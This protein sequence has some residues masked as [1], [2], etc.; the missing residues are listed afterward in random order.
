ME[1]DMAK[2]TI[3]NLRTEYLVN[4]EGID[5]KKPR[6]SW[7]LASESRGVVQTA[8]QILVSS[9]SE[10]LKKNRGNIWN[11]GTVKKQ[12]T[13]QIV[14][15]GKLLN[16]YKQYFWKV[17]VW[18]NKS[19]KPT[20]W[21]DAACW[22]MGIL[23]EKK[24][25]GDWIAY[26][27][28][29]I[30]D[31]PFFRKEIT[32]KKKVKRAM[33]YATSKGIYEAR[34]NGEKV[35]EDIFTPGWTDY[36]KRLYYNTYDVTG[37]LK[38]GR[39]AIGAILGEGWYKGPIGWSGRMHTYGQY[40]M[41]LANL[42]IEFADGTSTVIA[43][44]KT[45]KTSTGPIFLSTFLWGETYDSRQELGEWDK[46]GYDESDWQKVVTQGFNDEYWENSVN[47]MVRRTPPLQAYPNEPVRRTEYLDAQKVWQSPKGSWIFDLGQNFAG[48]A[49]IRVKEKAGT[50]IR[51]RYG[52]MCEADN[53][54][55]VEN[56]RSAWS[57]DTYICKGKGV[58]EWEPRFTFHG[59]RYVEITGITSKP[60]K[61][62]VTGVVTGS[63][64]NRVGD[65]SCS[66][67]MINQ[68]YSNTVWTQRANFLEIPTDCP[69]RDERLGWTGDAQAYIRT[70]SCNMDIAA[71]FKKWLVDLEDTQ[72][73]NGSVSNVAPSATLGNGGA[74]SGWG[75][76]VVICP[77]TIY[78]VYGDTTILRKHWNAMKK[79]IGY[80]KSTSKG[81]V[82]GQTHCF[83]DWLSINADT[84]KD[85]IQTAFF[86]YVTDLMVRMA[87]VL[88]KKKDEAEYTKLLKDIKKAFNKAFVKANGRIKGD[89]QTA[90]VLALHFDLLSEKLVPKAVKYL[91]NDIKKK[92]NHLSTG[93]LGTPYLLHVL[94]RYGHADL[95]YTLLENKTYPSW[96]YS[97]VNGATTI[98][99]RW[100][101]WTKEH[102]FGPTNMNSFSHYAYGAV[103]EWMFKTVAG[104]DLKESGFRKL[105]IEPIPGGSMK[106]ARGLYWSINGLVASEWSRQGK[107]L[108]LKVTV[109]ANTSALIHVPTSDAASVTESG[110]AIED[111]ADVERVASTKET[112]IVRVGSGAY[113]FKSKI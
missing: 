9:T 22:S 102:G 82:R 97:V 43:S 32:L 42:R 108:I 27:V 44:D 36:K 90:Y 101:G 91:V 28:Q 58:E 105:N 63:D 16:S 93:F 35:G 62:M 53:T 6:F 14:F 104:I 112:L 94:Q 70:A 107:N 45:W 60:D 75:D 74:D 11:S 109:P 86:A 61:S 49:V 24:W 5:E 106:K 77:W 98:W 31:C 38:K 39:N 66:N 85:V 30:H 7:E 18:T 8:F 84:P 3:E 80:L 67:N 83:G 87:E 33:L 78:Q 73:E 76:A 13:N 37:M 81:L 26:P 89:T 59:F 113:K 34:I 40:I 56:L 15:K 55:Y 99:E 23:D 12:D 72:V 48:R 29:G 1:I 19:D 71:F 64:T 92:K 20:P 110:I 51:I 41:F 79:W 96:G 69:Q 21:S 54:L 25:K 57:T 47:K 111:S 103:G 2:I 100:N 65:F 88:K 68:L 52:E 46:P 17:R 95:A 10:G 4:P 50:V